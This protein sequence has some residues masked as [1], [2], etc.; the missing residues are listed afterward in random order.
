MKFAS[1]VIELETKE[2]LCIYNLTPQI[3]RIMDINSIESGHAL[4]FTRHTTTG[5]AINEN[6]ERLLEDLKVY[7]ANL[8]PKDKK[9]L[10]N[11]VHLRDVPPDEPLNAHS[12]LI[13]MM[14]N[15]SEYIPIVEGKLALGTWQSVLFFELDGSRKRTVFVQISGE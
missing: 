1:E 2:E 7:L 9:Y 12:H 14:L 4:V 10:H 5:I 13:A 11:D 8:A 6:E 3:Q 15:T